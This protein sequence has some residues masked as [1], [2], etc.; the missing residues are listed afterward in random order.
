MTTK[1]VSNLIKIKNKWNCCSLAVV[2]T[3]VNKEQQFEFFF[4]FFKNWANEISVI[5]Q[6]AKLLSIKFRKIKK[7]LM[8]WGFEKKLL[9]FTKFDTDSFDTDSVICRDNELILWAN[10]TELQSK[11]NLSSYL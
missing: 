5:W 3:T 8:C 6:L 2:K 4:F 7:N 11:I 10:K 1:S 9:I